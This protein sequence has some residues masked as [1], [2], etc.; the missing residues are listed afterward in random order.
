MPKV[1]THFEKPKRTATPS[2]DQWL[3]V[4]QEEIVKN[5][6][7]HLVPT[8]KKDIYA[9]IQ[10]DLESTKI[11]NILKA[12]AL[13]DYSMLRSQE[14]TYIDATTLPKSLM[15]AQNIV[16]KAKQEFE[17]MPSEVRELFHNDPEI[18]ISQMGT[19]EFLDKMAPYN[20]KMSEIQKAGNLKKY[21]DMVAERAK[22]EKDVEK[23]K[24]AVT[25]ES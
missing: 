2:G 24:G 3:Q 18:Y 10:E 15:E 25:N 9:M 1:Y 20:T 6:S 23:A 14:P 22:F 11:E 21:N 13:G 5:G 12:V 19:K 8:G 17:K 16:L 7:K 4:Y